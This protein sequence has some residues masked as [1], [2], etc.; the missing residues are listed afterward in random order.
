MSKVETLIKKLGS[1]FGV[2]NVKINTEHHIQVKVGLRK[3]PNGYCD[4]W[5]NKHK[6]LKLKLPLTNKIFDYVSID[7][8]IKKIKE[9]PITDVEK[10]KKAL[11]FSK[12]I[13]RSEDLSKKIGDGIFCDAGFKEGKSRISA[14]HIKG[15]EINA[16]SKVIRVEDNNKA[17]IQAVH[18]GFEMDFHSYIYLGFER[19]FHSYIY[20]DSEN[21]YNYFL[22][23]A[24]KYGTKS[25]VKWISR[26]LNKVADSLGNM[27]K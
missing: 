18:L 3:L 19:D 5:I 24:E 27:R 26:K 22:K 12:F 25:H 15:D 4:I 16:R 13:K 14:V 6:K 1:E 8:I 10:M 2:D 9:L 7:F 21:A 11:D 23:Q 17:E 20:T